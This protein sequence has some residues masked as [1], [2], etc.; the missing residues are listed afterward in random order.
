MV[1]PPIYIFRGRKFLTC[2]IT[3]F[4]L[5]L[6]PL[7]TCKLIRSRQ[8][9]SLARPQRGLE[10]S[11]FAKRSWISCKEVLIDPF[12]YVRWAWKDK[13]IFA[14]SGGS[15]TMQLC[16]ENFFHGN[17]AVL[18]H[19]KRLRAIR[20]LT[21]VTMNS[22]GIFWSNHSASFQSQSILC[23]ITR[24]PGAEKELNFTFYLGS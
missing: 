1:F 23:K 13:Y 16:R 21:L 19:L 22:L 5:S 6:Q 14:R 7:D 15:G 17:F 20:I 3:E 4:A 9:L 10:H 12:F 8:L 18:I 24:K 11:W 2:W